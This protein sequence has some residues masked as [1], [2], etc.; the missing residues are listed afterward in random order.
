M[1]LTELKPSPGFEKAIDVCGGYGERVERPE[2]LPAALR[3]G[4]DAVRAGTPALINV[5]TRGR[6]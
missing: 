3:R 1:P 5:L 6:H 2:D 4:M